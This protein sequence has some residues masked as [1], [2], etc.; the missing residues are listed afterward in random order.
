MARTPKVTGQVSPPDFERAKQIYHQDIRPER[1]IQRAAMQAQGAAWKELKA[2]THV[3]KP[4]FAAAVKVAEMEEADQQAWLRSFNGCLKEF[5]VT[6]H[7]DLA[8]QAEGVNAKE[9]P[10]VPV[11]ERPETP[12]ET[13]N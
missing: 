4:G 6:L 10:V 9:I 5:G 7:A 2:E 13:L 3:N 12:L 8:D 11:G 1:K